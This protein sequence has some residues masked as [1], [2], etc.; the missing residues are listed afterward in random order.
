[1][2]LYSDNQFWDAFLVA[3]LSFLLNLPATYNFTHGLLGKTVPIVNAR[4]CP[5]WQGVALH[6]TVLL[7]ILL[8]FIRSLKKKTDEE[9]SSVL[10]LNPG[11]GK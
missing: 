2:V 7:V 8:L 6:S 3:G 9:R 5:T 11:N 4:G 10:V 1:M